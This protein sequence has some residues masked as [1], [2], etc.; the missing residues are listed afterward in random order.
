MNFLHY[1]Y[2]K[3]SNMTRFDCLP[4]INIAWPLWLGT[5]WYLPFRDFSTWW[6]EALIAFIISYIIVLAI[7]PPKVVKENYDIWEKQY[8]DKTSLWFWL[9]FYSFIIPMW[10]KILYWINHPVTQ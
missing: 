5:L 3:A 9:Y 10:L 8:S 7:Y 2:V 6:I 1:L 4:R